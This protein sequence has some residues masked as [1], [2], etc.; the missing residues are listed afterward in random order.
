MRRRPPE[1]E[2]APRHRRPSS[3]AHGPRSISDARNAVSWLAT[4]CFLDRT[5]AFLLRLCGPLGPRASDSW[6]IA[7]SDHICRRSQEAAWKTFRSFTRC[8]RSPCRI[9][10]GNFPNR[11]QRHRWLRVEKSFESCCCDPLSGL[12]RP[13]ARRKRFASLS[14]C[15]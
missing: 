14:Q 13:I 2:D 5:I 1:R 8:K 10:I 15:R 6:T 9:S 3:V 12:S 7:R 4:T 11:L